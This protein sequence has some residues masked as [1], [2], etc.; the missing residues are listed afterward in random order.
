MSLKEL[1]TPINTPSTKFHFLRVPS[2]EL[3]MTCKNHD[4]NST[5]VRKV[6]DFIVNYNVIKYASSLTGLVAQPEL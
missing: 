2:V 5:L 3:L 6:K 1:L 4:R